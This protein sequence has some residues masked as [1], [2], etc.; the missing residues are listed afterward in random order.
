MGWRLLRV[1]ARADLGVLGQRLLRPVQLLVEH[2]DVP[3]ARVLLG[4]FQLP[5]CARLPPD[6]TPS[7]GELRRVAARA[8]DESLGVLHRLVAP[9]HE[10]F[11]V[12]EGDVV[13][14]VSLVLMLVSLVCG[15][16]HG[17]TLAR[18]GTVSVR[19][20]VRRLHPVPF[21][22]YVCWSGM[23]S[24]FLLRY[25]GRRPALACDRASLKEV[26]VCPT[27]AASAQG[28]PAGRFAGLPRRI[29][30]SAAAAC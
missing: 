9:S 26:D 11:L 13:V 28:P 8:R 29:P 18:R 4:L 3:G 23:L 27:W 22:G 15:L 12:L 19:V 16:A 17:R 2:D 21:P 1:R 14:V 25:T 10:L 5:Q 24:S 30:P 20:P 7:P 6:G